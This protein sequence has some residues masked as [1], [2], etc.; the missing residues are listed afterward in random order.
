MEDTHR[1][2]YR[3][4]WPLYDELKAAAEKNRRPLNAEL[5]ARLEST[6]PQLT[7]SA[8]ADL[9]TLHSTISKMSLAELMTPAEITMFAERMLGIV[10]QARGTGKPPR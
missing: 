3:L 4:P 5:V 10:Q 7:V 6:F 9:P 1:S 8:D 2:Q